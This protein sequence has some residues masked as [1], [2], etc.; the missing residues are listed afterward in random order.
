MLQSLT[1]CFNDACQFMLEEISQI[2]PTFS[3]LV[4]LNLTDSHY[5]LPPFPNPPQKYAIHFLR[6]TSLVLWMHLSALRYTLSCIRIPACKYVDLWSRISQDPVFSN[7]MEHLVLVISSI[8]QSSQSVG[9]GFWMVSHFSAL[10]KYNPPKGLQHGGFCFQSSTEAPADIGWLVRNIPL[11]AIPTTVELR[12]QVIHNKLRTILN[13]VSCICNV[14]RLHLD[15]VAGKA[16]DSHR[17]EV[18]SCLCKPWT[19]RVDA[20]CWLFPHVRELLLQ[21]FGHKTASEDLIRLV[22]F[23]N[24][25]RAGLSMV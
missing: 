16:A 19:R 20:Q 12:I 22:S 4:E 24:G 13:D 8:V 23:R 18:V 9:V 15:L 25:Q 1:I 7:G 6:L 2:L 5:G 10:P 14:T 17:K 3:E 11:E 21:G